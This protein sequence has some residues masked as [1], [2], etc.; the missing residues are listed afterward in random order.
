VEWKFSIEMQGCGNMKMMFALLLLVP[1]LAMSGV[2]M[3]V[4][5]ATGK[6]SFTD[7]AC[8]KA[9]SREEVRVN[10]TNLDSGAR[11]GQRGSAKKTWSSDMD[12][13]KTGEHYNQQRRREMYNE[14]A[15][16]SAS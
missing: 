7:K 14:K 3:C 9:A 11:G 4:D 13:R 1:Q 10:G 12:T 8:A 5:P 15:T 6:T 16:A 2:Y